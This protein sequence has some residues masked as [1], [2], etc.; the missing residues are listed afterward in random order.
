MNNQ[1]INEAL[2]RL[3]NLMNAREEILLEN[4]GEYTEEVESQDLLIEDLKIL[5]T[6]EGVDSLG[7]WLKAEE[8]S[9]ATRKAERDMADRRVKNQEAKIDFIKHQTQRVLGALE[10]DNIKGRYYSFATATSTTTTVDKDLLNETYYDIV[11]GAVKKFIPND[12]RI[13]LSASVKA[14]PEGAELPPY[15]IRKTTPT[16]RFIKPRAKKEE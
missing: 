15:Y 2:L 14:V 8:D 6:T 12:V 16:C 1:E 9:L 7:R 11:I 10:I 13:T 4:G 5:L 3:S